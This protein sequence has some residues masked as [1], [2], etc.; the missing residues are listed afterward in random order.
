[1]ANAVFRATWVRLR[2]LPFRRELLVKKS[3]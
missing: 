2:D 3:G 1:V